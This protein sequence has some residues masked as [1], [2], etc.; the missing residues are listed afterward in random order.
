MDVEQQPPA[1]QAW[2]CP[3]QQPASL[4]PFSSSVPRDSC[5]DTSVAWNAEAM[6]TK[7]P[8]L[9]SGNGLPPSLQSK[10]LIVW[11]LHCFHTGSNTMR[12][13]IETGC[14]VRWVEPTYR[15]K[16]WWISVGMMDSGTQDTS[17]LPLFKKRCFDTYCDINVK[18]DAW[19]NITN[20]SDPGVRMITLHYRL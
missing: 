19:K 15:I 1:P 2:F 13:I 18:N 12:Q 11:L 7:K 17:F 3:W 14:S 6:S 5:S 10:G 20:G 9:A 8:A 4:R 16:L